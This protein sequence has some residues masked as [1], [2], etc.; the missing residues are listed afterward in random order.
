MTDNR[1]FKKV[2][3]S[4]NKGFKYT[5]NIFKRLILAIIKVGKNVFKCVISLFKKK[6]QE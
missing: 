5:F 2:V 6:S 3:S 1:G 4:I